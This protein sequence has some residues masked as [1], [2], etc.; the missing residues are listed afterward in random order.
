MT[1]VEHHANALGSLM[2]QV[3]APMSH[4]HAS[5]ALRCVPA[6]KSAGKWDIFFALAI[7]GIISVLILPVPPMLLDLLLGTSITVAVPILMT[8]LFVAKPLELS[9]FPPSCS[10]QRCCA[11][12]STSRPPALSSATATRDRTRLA[13]WDPC[14]RQ[15]RHRWFGTHRR[16]R[17]RYPSPSSNRGDPPKVRAIIAEVSAFQFGCHAR[18]Q[19]AID[20]D[21][22]ERLAQRQRGGKP[23]AASWRRKRLLRRRWTV[24]ANSS[25]AMRSPACSS[26][27]Q[28]VGGMVIGIVINDLSFSAAVDTYT[29]FTI[30]DGLV[31]R[32]WP[33]I[34]SRQQASW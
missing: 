14:L 19:M 29:K 18:K 9:S 33:L 10:S 30:G 21:F 16:N 2:A 7:L 20:A 17:L 1:V 32:S 8:S 15:L 24:P 22:I 13:M 28:P 26:F 31:A 3:P 25:V 23:S 5:A 6:L 4:H 12:R 11:S 34:V 27:H